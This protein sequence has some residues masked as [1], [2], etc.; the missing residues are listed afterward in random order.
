[1]KTT[2]HVITRKNIRDESY[3]N[4]VQLQR[5]TEYADPLAAI[6]FSEKRWA[7]TKDECGNIIAIAEGFI[8]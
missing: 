6:R 3:F 5:L 7:V 2:A 4:L 8:R 1:M